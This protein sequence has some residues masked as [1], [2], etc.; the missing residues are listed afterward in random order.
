MANTPKSTDHAAATGTKPRTWTGRIVWWFAALMGFMVAGVLSVA[1]L[2]AI[3]LAIAYPNL[4]D[5]KST[6]LNSS[7]G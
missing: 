5:R 1:I 2:I 4:P 7:H 6:R 3:A